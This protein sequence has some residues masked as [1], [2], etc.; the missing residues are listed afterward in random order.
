MLT[1]LEY[2]EQTFG[3][4]FRERDTQDR[5]VCEC[6]EDGVVIHTGRGCEGCKHE[7]TTIDG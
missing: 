7:W 5:L 2:C 1:K 4:V 6:I 3:V